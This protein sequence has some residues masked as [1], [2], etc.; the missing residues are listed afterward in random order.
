[1]IVWQ[2]AQ[3]I[4]CVKKKSPHTDTEVSPGTSCRPKQRFSTIRT[5]KGHQTATSV[6]SKAI[7]LQSWNNR[8]TKNRLPVREPLAQYIGVN[9]RPD[10]TAS[11]QL[12]APGNEPTSPTEYKV[13]NKKIAHMKSSIDTGLTHI[14]IDV[15]NM[16]LIFMTDASFAN[17]RGFTCQL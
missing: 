12:V 17:A 14:P 4:S 13:L 11:I 7:I 10:V 2:P 1:M 15:A 9:T 8:P 6:C 5:S 3:I 16:H